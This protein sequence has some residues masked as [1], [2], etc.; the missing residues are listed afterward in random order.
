MPSGNSFYHRRPGRLAKDREEFLKLVAE[1]KR[2]A[3]KNGYSQEQLTSE[4][5]VTKMTVNHWL[6]GYSLSAK[7]ESIERLKNFLATH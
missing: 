2:L 3:S 1:L 7:R 5:G 6:T 4:I